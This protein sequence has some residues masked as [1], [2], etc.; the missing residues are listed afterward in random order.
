[1]VDSMGDRVDFGKVLDD[2]GVVRTGEE[3]VA[4]CMERELLRGS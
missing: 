3:A 1:M 4:V 2:E